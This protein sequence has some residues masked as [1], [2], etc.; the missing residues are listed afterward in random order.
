M[1][2]DE[3]TR[4]DA[5]ALAA[6]VASGKVSPLELTEAAIAAIE[7][8]NPALNAVV[9]RMYDEARDAARG[10]LPEGP[11][12]GVPM[13]VKDFDGFVAGAPFTASCRFLEGFVPKTDSEAI[14]RLRRAGLLLLAK[15]NCPELAVLGTTE[16]ELR[17]PTRNPY[18]P[19]RS[20]GGS[21]G[22][23]AALVAARAV[24]VGHGGDGGGSLRIPGNHCGLVG[25]KATR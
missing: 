19:A 15:T 7:R 21:S 8:V 25:L 24:P 6:H 18:D 9:H 1:D 12:R 14:A 4:C 17:G 23:S 5:T 13:V 10:P 2:V 11:L 16:P 3:Y 20:S 22:G